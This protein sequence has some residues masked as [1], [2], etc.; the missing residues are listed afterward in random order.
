M[1]ALFHLVHPGLLGPRTWFKEA[2]QRP[3]ARA[4]DKDAKPLDLELGQ[5]RTKQL[6]EKIEKHFLRREKSQ[7]LR[8]AGA[9][10]GPDQKP[11]VGGAGAGAAAA[12]GA[13]AAPLP[14]GMGRKNDLIIWLKM[15]PLQRRIY[16]D[17]LETKDV[18][19]ALNQTQ[20]PLASL[21]VL[22]KIADHPA[23]VSRTYNA[24]TTIFF[25]FCNLF[26]CSYSEVL[27]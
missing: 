8:G 4:T 5:Q 9:G 11:A 7:V 17:F 15:Q 23:L 19:E 16:L 13:P 22:K 3:I 10:G 18:K 25:F 12:G 20:A 2:F 21:T 24:W 1:W 26:F 14:P 6:R 27:S